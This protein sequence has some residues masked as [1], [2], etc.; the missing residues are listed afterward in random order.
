MTLSFPFF[1]WNCHMMWYYSLDYIPTHDRFQY[2][3]LVATFLKGLVGIF[4]ESFGSSLFVTEEK[5]GRPGSIAAAS[6]AGIRPPSQPPG[7]A[8]AARHSGDSPGQH[9]K[10]MLADALGE[11]PGWF[12]I[13][14]S[15]RGPMP[16]RQCC[17]VPLHGQL[18]VILCHHQS[19]FTAV[20]NNLKS[21]WF[22]T[23]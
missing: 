19:A 21:Q 3:W 1:V 8:L 18:T 6:H 12:K 16:G 20:T 9:F 2:I 5:R 23:S 7:T 22:L 17:R 13:N 10:E 11:K 14:P 15:F 4:L